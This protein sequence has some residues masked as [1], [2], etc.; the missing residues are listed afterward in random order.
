V[1]KPRT[2]SF[3]AE[4]KP[5]EKRGINLLTLALPVV[6][7][8]VMALVMRQWYYLMFAALSPLTYFANSWGEGRRQKSK[9]A[10]QRADFDNQLNTL[11]VE[12]QAASTSRTPT[13]AISGLIHAWSSR[14]RSCR[15]WSC[16]AE[17]PPMRTGSACVAE[18]LTSHPNLPSPRPARSAGATP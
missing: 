16:G 18:R 4:P 9:E 3:P 2:F 10:G 12:V 11:R 13:C 15:L 7:A 5:E 1:W 6:F 8:V 14:R 17:G